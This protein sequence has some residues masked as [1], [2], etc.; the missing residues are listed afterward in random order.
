MAAV[1]QFSDFSADC[2]SFSDLHKNKLGGKAVYLNNKS[3]QKLL[4]QLPSARAP[5]GLSSFE[6]AKT[7]QVSYSVPLS[8]DDQNLQET[9]KEVDEKVLKFVADNSLEILGQKYTIDVL[10][11]LYSPLLRPSKGEYAPQLKLKVQVGRNGDFIP[12]AYDHQ[13]NPVPLDSLD[14]GGMIQTIIDINQIWIVDKKFGVS[15]RLEQVMKPASVKL[16]ECAFASSDE[17]DIPVDSD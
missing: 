11:V 9:F 5:F 16:N 4:V 12:R 7:K 17:I 15:V 8:L 13:R 2:I 6:D 1:T 14:K 10:R 3:G